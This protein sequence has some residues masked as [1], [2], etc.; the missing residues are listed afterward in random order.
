[1][2]KLYGTIK[3]SELPDITDKDPQLLG[4]D[5]DKNIGKLQA[6]SLKAIITHKVTVLEFKN[7]IL[8][9]ELVP[10]SKY[11]L[12]DFI[13]YTYM[14]FFHN[15]E[16][17][18]GLRITNLDVLG[19]D[20]TTITPILTALT[21]STY[22]ENALLREFPS[23]TI[24][25]YLP[26]TSD[27]RDYYIDRVPDN[28]IT[29]GIITY[30]HDSVNNIRCEFDFINSVFM[31]DGVTDS[32]KA[33]KTLLT[34][35]DIN[36]TY[37]AYS[38]FPYYY[39]DGD[40]T[41]S[42]NTCEWKSL[43][44]YNPTPGESYDIYRPLTEFTDR[45]IPTDTRHH[46]FNDETPLGDKI[47]SVSTMAVSN[48]DISWCQSKS[49]SRHS[50]VYR[51]YDM[52]SRCDGTVKNIQI[53]KSFV[54]T[55]TQVSESGYAVSNIPIVVLGDNPSFS[56]TSITNKT[57]NKR[58]YLPSNLSNITVVNSEFIY[59]GSNIGTVVVSHSLGISIHES[60]GNVNIT[61]S[62]FCK[63]GHIS[64]TNITD[65]IYLY[66]PLIQSS[67]FSKCSN[68]RLSKVLSSQV[69]YCESIDSW[70][71]SSLIE[72]SVL[73]NIGI[74]SG[75]YINC[76]TLTKVGDKLIYNR[77]YNMLSDCINCNLSNIKGIH[78]CGTFAP[79]SGILNLIDCSISGFN[80][81]AFSAKQGKLSA[82]DDPS[83]DIIWNWKIPT[84][85]ISV[86]E[87]LN[88]DFYVNPNFRFYDSL[89]MIV[90]L[91]LNGYRVA[92]DLLVVS[93]YHELSGSGTYGTEFS[94]CFIFKSPTQAIIATF[95]GN[96]E[97]TH[98]I[99]LD[100]YQQPVT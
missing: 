10:G 56:C 54:N 96:L 35:E 53:S 74:S 65:C 85:Y 26:T 38:F 36:V 43:T 60:G 63:L 99:N 73:T 20:Y 3:F 37:K 81:L 8:G 68:L 1:M 41:A 55:T 69:T 45:F 48:N 33:P 11:E 19:S 18:R 58:T 64:A 75:M 77:F 29:N 76:K 30:M 7:L 28:A 47:G 93:S 22:S 51:F 50:L 6:N 5:K 13:S 17:T 49:A 78:N 32:R 2:D 61:S 67:T 100:I 46:Y 72:A 62:L 97:R 70:L 95:N 79:T 80:R 39:V 12:I 83:T 23:I 88:T 31:S 71:D 90:G 86:W 92:S 82:T 98:S 57:F 16:I 21:D 25:F 44:N 94:E 87:Q 34:L 9:K 89:G 14:P 42:T 15:A 52:F 4:M 27:V 59:I 91:Q 40:F 84:N 24:G 66:S